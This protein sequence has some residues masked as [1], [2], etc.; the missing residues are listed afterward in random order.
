MEWKC[1]VCG[2]NMEVLDEGD[3]SKGILPNLDGGTVEIGF[4]WGSALDCH[5]IPGVWQSAIH[6]NC[7]ETVRSRCRHVLVHKN[8][9][10]EEQQET[11]YGHFKPEHRL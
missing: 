3:D 8:K 7:F 6:D 5:M 11:Q 4:G 2:E 9:Q 1:I 10:F